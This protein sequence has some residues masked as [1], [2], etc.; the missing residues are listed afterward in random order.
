MNR[1]IVFAIMAFVLVAAPVTAQETEIYPVRIAAS[2]TLQEEGYDHNPYNLIDGS[3]ETAW[4]EGTEG[5][6]EGEYVDYFVPKGTVIT[7]VSLLTGYCKS[8]YAFFNNNAVSEL[9]IQSGSAYENMFFTEAAGN[10]RGGTGWQQYVLRSPVISDG[11]VRFIIRDVREGTKYDDT[12]ISELHIYGQKAAGEISEQMSM[13][14]L[15]WLTSYAHWVYKRYIM[16]E[17]NPEEADVSPE[18]LSPEDYAFLLYWYQ[19]HH[20][21]KEYRIQ[22][23][24]EY[25]RASMDDLR[26]MLLALCGSGSE[27]E[28][29]TAWDVFRSEYVLFTEGDTYYMNGTGD[30]GA[31]GWYYFTDPVDEGTVEGM[32]C[33]SGTVRFDRGE[34]MAFKAYFQRTDSPTLNGWR[35]QRVSVGKI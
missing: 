13:E 14:E 9:C 17:D 20:Y 29:E 18:M 30:F 1:I 35:L 24:G 28:T 27:T 10:F 31:A 7:S 16:T 6:G 19:Y 21:D 23:T 8:D 5:D 25:N 2:S 22:T 34:D 26:E 11:T 4:V 3:H 12:C 32:R 15:N 33:V